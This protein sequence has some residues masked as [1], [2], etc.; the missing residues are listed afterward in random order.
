MCFY[1][2]CWIWML[3]GPLVFLVQI[4]LSH[5]KDIA[6]FYIHIFGYGWV[7]GGMLVWMVD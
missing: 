7:D 6:L 2:I 5:A 3:V 1:Q 4:H